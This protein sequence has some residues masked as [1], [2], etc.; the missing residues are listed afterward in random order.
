MS[1]LT[2]LLWLVFLM[3]T[4]NSCSTVSHRLGNPEESFG[5]KILSLRL[6]AEGYMI[7]LRFKVIEPEKAKPIFD[8]K[9][10]PYLIDARTGARFLVPDSPKIGSLRQMPKFPESKKDY[11]MLFAN[12]G[13]YLKKGDEVSLVIGD[14]VVGGIIIE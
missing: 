3:L 1:Y 4:I 11:F 7:D 9:L 12:P 6:S 5:I 10:K 8:Y 14:L 13:R 2:F